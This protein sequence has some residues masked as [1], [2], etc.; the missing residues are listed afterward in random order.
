M[1]L[2]KMRKVELLPTRDCEAGYSPAFS[3]PNYA[4]NIISKQNILLV[5]R[6]RVSSV[7]ILPLIYKNQFKL[8]QL[9]IIVYPNQQRTNEHQLMEEQWS[10][11]QPTSLTAHLKATAVRNTF[12][13][14]SHNWM[15]F[16]HRP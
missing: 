9:T 11:Q 14:R 2:G 6:W 12:P 3:W 16:I 5:E 1:F 8:R 15:H 10:T 4:W 7:T 13:L